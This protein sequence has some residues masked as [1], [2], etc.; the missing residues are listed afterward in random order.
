MSIAEDRDI[1]NSKINNYINNNNLDRILVVKAYQGIGKTTLALRNLKEK[2]KLFVYLSP[3]HMLTQEISERYDIQHIKGKKHYCSNTKIKSLLEEH[4]DT[5]IYCRKFCPNYSRCRY[6]TMIHNLYNTC[7]SWAGVHSHINNIYRKYIDKY[8]NIVDVSVIDEN[9]MNSLRNHYIIN[10]NMIDSVRYLIDNQPLLDFIDFSL[11]VMDRKTIYNEKNTKKMLLKLKGLDK[12]S[13]TL[14][15]EIINRYLLNEDISNMYNFVPYL[16]DLSRYID[17]NIRSSGFMNYT[18]GY[19][20]MVYYNTLDI[21]H[22]AILLDATFVEDLNKV[23]F[24]KDTKFDVITLKEKYTI[25]QHRIQ[26]KGDKRYSYPM[27]TLYYNNKLTNSFYFLCKLTNL[28]LKQKEV[29]RALII[30]RKKYDI[31]DNIKKEVGKIDKEVSF[32]HYGANRGLDKYN[33]YDTVI[34]FATPFPNP[35]YIERESKLLNVIPDILEES[36]REHE[37]LHS[38]HRIRPFGRESRIYVLSSVKIFKDDENIQFFTPT[39]LLKM[40]DKKSSE[41]QNSSFGVIR[42]EIVDI[43]NHN[44]VMKVNEVVSSVKGSDSLKIEVINHLIS[45]GIVDKLK[46]KTDD[47]GRPPEFLRLH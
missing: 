25:Q 34:L 17:N 38:L 8:E 20:S 47:K 10:R 37:M 46:I 6:F 30:S 24:P 39:E 13:E 14:N 5:S 27:S 40:L 35:R 16:S 36:N 4:C 21:N 42:Q 19:M 23:F 28:I 44:K 12:V 41:D 3:N 7:D 31:L 11:D 22:S 32:I 45:N 26:F 1:L 9:F 15:N 43:L 29:E 18:D 33:G 2:E